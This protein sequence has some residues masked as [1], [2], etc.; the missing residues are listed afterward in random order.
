VKK[1]TDIKKTYVHCLNS[2]LTATTRTLCC[3]LENYQTEDGLKVPEVLRKYLPGAPEF[4]PFAKELPK[5][6]TSQKVKAKAD[7]AAKT[8]VAKAGDTPGQ[9]AEKLAQVTV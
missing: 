6:T 9:V 8:K 2:T 7:G 1:Q 4:I 3:I 5:N